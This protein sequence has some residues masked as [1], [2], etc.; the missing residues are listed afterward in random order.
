MISYKELEQFGLKDKE[1]RVYLAALKLGTD[2]VQNIA[3]EADIHRVSTYDILSSLIDQGL[4]SQIIKGKKRFFLAE[5]PEKILDSIKSKE[6]QFSNILPELKAM[7]N[8]GKVRPRVMYF[9]GREAVWKAYEDRLKHKPELKENLVYGSSE[10]L[11][12]IYPNE[13]RQFTRDRLAKGIKAKIIV[14]QSASGR[15][16]AKTAK[17]QLREVKFLPEGKFFK[18]STIIYGDRVMVVSWESMMLVIIEDKNNA[19]NQRFIFNL[20]WQYLP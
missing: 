11:L 2:T 5:S 16:E 17:D 19:E 12:T 4:V 20:L 9:E 6:E 14:E 7:Q 15:L 13:Y 1:A 3:K 8:K 18:A 10:K